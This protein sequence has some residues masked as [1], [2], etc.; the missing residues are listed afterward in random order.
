MSLLPSFMS[1]L[2]KFI[3]KRLSVEIE[4]YMSAAMSLLFHVSF[5]KFH[6][7]FTKFHWKEIEIGD[8]EVHECSRLHLVFYCI[9][10]S[11]NLHI[12]S[13]HSCHLSP[14]HFIS[15]PLK[16]SW[17]HD[18]YPQIIS[19]I[20]KSFHLSSNHVIYLQIIPSI[21]KSCHLFSNHFIYSQISLVSF[22]FIYP[23]T[24]IVDLV[25]QVSFPKFHWKE[26][27]SGD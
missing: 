26:I 9:S 3:D 6:V 19:S 22:Y 24:S 5:T 4:R 2:P 13:F 18:I 8:C 12:V 16:S 21:L 17:F 14:N 25:F 15:S 23:Q 27:E 1:L 7:S 20:L 10:L 11:S